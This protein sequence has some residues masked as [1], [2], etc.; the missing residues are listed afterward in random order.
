MLTNLQGRL[1]ESPELASLQWLATDNVNSQLASNWQKPEVNA[2]TLA[3][4]QYTS[5]S[6]G[7]PKGV[8]LTH[9]NLLHNEE[10]IRRSF[11]HTEESLVVGWLP[12]FHDMGL[13][14]NVL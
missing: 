5:G 4:L 2:D 13:I 12:L 1:A 9:G 7:T 8:M 6:T 14:G 10:M 3:F 11:Q